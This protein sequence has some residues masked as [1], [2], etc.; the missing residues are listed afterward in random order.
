MRDQTIIEELNRMKQ[1]IQ[2]LENSVRLAFTGQEIRGASLQSLLIKKGLVTDEE[3]TAEVG[4]TI[5]KMQ[6]Q[7]EEAAKKQATEIIKPNAEQVQQVT[8]QPA[9]E[10]PPQA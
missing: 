6:Q 8:N 2:M 9:P 4:A 1:Y 7:A 3:M 5:T 10:V